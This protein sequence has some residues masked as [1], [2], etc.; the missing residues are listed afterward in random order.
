MPQLDFV[1]F[2]YI[3]H[4]LAISYLSVYIFATLFFLKPVFKELFS[5]YTFSTYLVLEVI[6]LFALY[7][8]KIIY[9]ALLRHTPK[10]VGLS[11]SE[12]DKVPW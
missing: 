12:P 10:G 4:T 1:S 11:K 7:N 5:F 9:F 2:H 8:N 3:L 6:S